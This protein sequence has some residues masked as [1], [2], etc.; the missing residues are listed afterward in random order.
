MRH[1]RKKTIRNKTKI[2]SKPRSKSSKQ[3]GGEPVE[4]FIFRSDKI[5]MR[6][7]P[8]N[9]KQIGIIHLTESTAV[10]AIRE[11]GTGIANI[12]GSKGFDNTIFDTLRNDTLNSLMN[13]L[14]KNQ[15]VYNV[16]MDYETNPQGTIFLH[17]YG[18]LCE[19]IVVKQN[20]LKI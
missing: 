1:T 8:S 13:K 4:T 14:A 7:I 11:L 20:V 18:D 2:R 16:R 12:F 5:S 10:N 9:Y 15:K 17:V 6:S 3:K 19:P